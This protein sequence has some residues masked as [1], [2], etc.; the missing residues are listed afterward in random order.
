MPKEESEDLKGR[1]TAQALTLDAVDMGKD[2]V[3]G[4]L[5]IIVK[6]GACGYDVAKQGVI[7]LAER[8][9][10]GAVGIAEKEQG[11]LLPIRV[12]FEGIDIGEFA[13][14]VGE[15]DGEQITETQPGIDHGSLR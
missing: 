7:F 15:D 12:P 2:E 9:L 3:D 5:R 14:V 13:A 8:L 11:F 6:G 1:F 4:F 10:A